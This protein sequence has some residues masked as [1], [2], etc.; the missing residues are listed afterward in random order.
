MIRGY[1]HSLSC[2]PTAYNSR[3]SDRRLR[4]ELLSTCIVTTVGSIPFAEAHV[5]HY[6]PTILDDY[7]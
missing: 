1:P 4:H 7:P 5:I 2:D 6:G 3:A